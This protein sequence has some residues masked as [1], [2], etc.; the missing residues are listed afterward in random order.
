MPT[1][2]TT[3]PETLTI[4]YRNH[5]HDHGGEPVAPL[6]SIGTHFTY[7]LDQPDRETITYST[8][9][10]GILAHL[11]PGYDPTHTTG[12]DPTGD[13]NLEHDRLRARAT[14][15]Y[16]VTINHAAQ[17]IATGVDDTITTT[18]RAATDLHH[19]LT[20]TTLPTW[21]HELP[22]ILNAAFYQPDGD[23]PAP[24][25]NVIL[26]HTTDPDQ[27]LADLATAGIINLSVHSSHTTQPAQTHLDEPSTHSDLQDAT[28]HLAQLLTAHPKLP[29]THQQ[30]TDTI[31][32]IRH[33]LDTDPTL[34]PAPTSWPDPI[35]TRSATTLL[36]HLTSHTQASEQQ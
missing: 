30:L 1:P 35:T 16:G 33:L 18:L 34:A 32:R 36:N 31:T 21:H 3:T 15:G 29:T 26:L 5:P 20:A 6:T 24:Q 2:T 25:G 13:R 10:D 14:H 17:A 22:L 9:A 19:P 7:A 11:I 8:H 23:L 27:Y 4:A 12:D 28:T